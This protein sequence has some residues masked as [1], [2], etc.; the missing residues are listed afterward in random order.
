[1]D[2]PKVMESDNLLAYIADLGL[3]CNNLEIEIQLLEEANWHLQCVSNSKI[4]L[5]PCP[6]CDNG[7]TQRE[8]WVYC[9][10]CGRKVKGD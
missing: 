5:A 2:R 3:Y 1:M 8:N 10:Y 6:I 7:E 4:E 9:P